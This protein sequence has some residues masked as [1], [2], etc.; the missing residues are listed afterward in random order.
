MS[1]KKNKEDKYGDN[2]IYESWMDNNV[3]FPIAKK[4][5]DP[6]RQY[7][8]TPNM[9]TSISTIFT[10]LAIYFIYLKQYENAAISYALGY[11]F[12]CIDGIMARKYN[13]ASNF[14]MAFDLVSDNISNLCLIIFLIY[15]RGIFN[16]YVPIIIIISFIISI[17]YGMNEAIACYKKTG[18]DNF[19]KNKIKEL[20][21]E[22]N[23]IYDMFL[24][25]IRL[26]YNSY[27]TFFPKY[28]KNNI[29][30]WLKFLKEFGPGNYCLIIIII[31][32]FLD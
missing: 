8:L 17:S 24:F 2:E 26:S 18:N 20:K 11:I 19:Y 9:V 32:L 4:L 6:L 30:K 22:N 7:G 16:Y 1:N 15:S 12:D 10:F 3:F 29:Y 23:I 31:I 28:N 5:V 27:K 25:I 14:G 13:M 21:N